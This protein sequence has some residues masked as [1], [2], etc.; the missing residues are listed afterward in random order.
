V[1]SWPFPDT[2]RATVTGLRG[3]KKL[4]SAVARA[5]PRVERSGPPSLSL[6]ESPSFSPC[7]MIITWLGP[8]FELLEVM[9]IYI[10]RIVQ[11]GTTS[12]RDAGR[13]LANCARRAAIFRLGRRAA[14][15]A[16]DLGI[17]SGSEQKELWRWAFLLA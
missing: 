7:R 10:N 12:Q 11:T 15:A 13:N 4:G 17:S 9:A 14:G 2:Q 5:D 8:L 3:R 16:R 6:E 1:K